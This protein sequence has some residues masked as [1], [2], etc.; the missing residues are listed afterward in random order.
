M[1]EKGDMTIEISQN[2]AA[3][4]NASTYMSS[5]SSIIFLPGDTVFNF[6]FFIVTASKGSGAMLLKAGSKRRRTKV[7]IA[8]AKLEET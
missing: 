2:L 3:V 8:D 7:E 1:E 5:R 4:F 6:L